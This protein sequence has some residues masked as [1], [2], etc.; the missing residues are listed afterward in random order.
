MSSWYLTGQIYDNQQR[1]LHKE[2]QGIEDNTVVPLIQGFAR[3][4]SLPTKQTTLLLTHPEKVNGSLMPGHRVCAIHAISSHR[5]GILSPHII[6]RRRSTEQDILR[7]HTTFGLIFCTTFVQ[8]IVIIILIYYQSLSLISYCA[9][10]IN[11]TLSQECRHRK[12]H[13]TYRVWYDL[14]FRHPLGILKYIP[15]EGGG[16]LLYHILSS[17]SSKINPAQVNQHD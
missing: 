8:H 17:Q 3:Q 1:D 9:Q 13:S 2:T 4:P 10:S 7:Y 15:V 12:K 6:T 11:S 14:Q 16:V 5:V